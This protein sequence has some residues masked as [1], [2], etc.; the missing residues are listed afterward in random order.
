MFISPFSPG[1]VD[2]NVQLVDGLLEPFLATIGRNVR[3][4]LR[5][6]R[7]NRSRPG[8]VFLLN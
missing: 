6:A 8:G 5:I 1:Q 7:S 4:E 3:V 2:G